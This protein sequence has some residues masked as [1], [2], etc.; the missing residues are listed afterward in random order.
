M[1]RNRAPEPATGGVPPELLSLA[2]PTWSDPA[3]FA[4]WMER[5]GLPP[6]KAVGWFPC[7]SR[8]RD[9]WS[10]AH[11][12][13]DAALKAAGVAATGAMARGMFMSGAAAPVKP[14]PYPLSDAEHRAALAAWHAA[15]D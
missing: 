9:S 1:S 15:N 14:F 8:A 11:G 6:S 10:A 7:F 5:H 13:N 2:D 3:L 4:A 12:Y